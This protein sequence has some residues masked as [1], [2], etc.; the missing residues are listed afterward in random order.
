[1]NYSFD[2]AARKFSP[3]FGKIHTEKPNTIYKN[4]K[5]FEKK[6]SAKKFALPN[7][8]RRGS[9]KISSQS[10]GK[11]DKKE[12]TRGKNSSSG[13]VKRSFEKPDKISHQ[14]PKVFAQSLKKIEEKNFCWKKSFAKYSS[15]NREGN[16]GRPAEKICRLS[17][18]LLLK[19]LQQR[20]SKFKV[21]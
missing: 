10:P 19:I 9:Q 1:M 5:T 17:I 21:P 13:Q 8:L 4:Q 7:P 15:G 11:L 14:F 20:L 12:T 16:F 6:S 2:K 3:N 18:K